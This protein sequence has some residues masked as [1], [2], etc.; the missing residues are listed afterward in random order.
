[1]IKIVACLLL[2]SASSCLAVEPGPGYE[3][4][5]RDEPDADLEFFGGPHIDIVKELY[6]RPDE[7]T[8]AFKIVLSSLA[9]P[10]QKELLF[11]YD[12]AADANLSP[13]GK[14]FIV[15]DRSF[16]NNCD[17]RLFKQ[18]KGL[19]FAEVKDARIPQKA[20][21][22]FISYNKYPL[23]I[24]KHLSECIV[25]SEV[26]SDNSKSLL[27]RISKG[28]TGEPLWVYNWR[29]IYDLTTGK[30]STDLKVLNRG[31]ILPGKYLTPSP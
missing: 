12:R 28:Q 5:S 27:L 19:K 2:I 18:Q 20:I 7:D 24:R 26:W 17:P 14:W 16:R 4:V 15:N 6:R 30:I 9:D 29:C 25:E 23:S 8:P 13:D 31:A 1:V 22:F 3:L 10:S 11:A 21:N